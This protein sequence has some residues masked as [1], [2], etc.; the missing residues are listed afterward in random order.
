MEEKEDI[1]ETVY[2]KNKKRILAGLLPCNVCINN[3]ENCKC[4]L[5]RKVL[6][7]NCSYFSIGE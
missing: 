7:V 1:Q 5:V 2:E 3:Q 6:M 4:L